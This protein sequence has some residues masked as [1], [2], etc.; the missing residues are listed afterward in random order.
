VC[1][2]CRLVDLE[3][4]EAAIATGSNRRASRKIFW[5][6]LWRQTNVCKN[7]RYSSTAL[8]L[9]L[10]PRVAIFYVFTASLDV[11]FLLAYT[12]ILWYNFL[13]KL[14]CISLQ[15]SPSVGTNVGIEM[16]ASHVEFDISKSEKCPSW[17]LW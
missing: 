3:F 4:A 1:G 6:E 8:A 12:L 17:D 15:R 5:A 10:A 2:A 11:P 13:T 9:K 16:M 7:F 14:H